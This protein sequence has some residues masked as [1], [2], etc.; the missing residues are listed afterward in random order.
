MA[1]NLDLS[2]CLSLSVR[3]SR[4]GFISGEI[5]TTEDIPVGSTICSPVPCYVSGRSF[6]EATKTYSLSVSDPASAILESVQM[7]TPEWHYSPATRPLA[8]MLIPVLE[9]TGH[10]VAI[11]GRFYCRGYPPES[12]VRWQDWLRMTLVSDSGILHFE[13]SEPSQCGWLLATLDAYSETTVY[14]ENDKVLSATVVDDP[15]GYANLV[16]VSVHDEWV[17][18]KGIEPT[19]VVEKI[20]GLTIT[21][22]SIGDQILSRKEVDSVSDIEQTETWE[23]DDEGY[24]TK[25]KKVTFSPDQVRPDQQEKEESIL[26][27][28]ISSDNVYSYQKRTVLSRWDWWVNDPTDDKLQW[29]LCEKRIEET[30]GS[31]DLAGYSEVVT[32]LQEEEKSKSPLPK[33]MVNVSKTR[34]RIYRSSGEGKPSQERVLTDRWKWDWYIV[35]VAQDLEWCWVPD[36]GSVV[37]GGENVESLI[38]SP[39]QKV[40]SIHLE[41]TARDSESIAAL[42]EIKKE[43]SVVGIPDMESLERYARGE[44]KECSRIRKA[45]L[46]IPL[47]G[48]GD[49]HE[50]MPIPGCLVFWKGRPWLVHAVETNLPEHVLTVEMELEPPLEEIKQA[51]LGVPKAAEAIIDLIKKHGKTTTNVERGT[52]AGRISQGRYLVDVGGQQKVRAERGLVSGKDDIPIGSTVLLA[53]PSGREPHWTILERPREATVI[54][55]TVE[56]LPRD[57]SWEVELGP[58][59]VVPQGNPE[60]YPM[61]VDIDWEVKKGVDKIIGY[62][63]RVENLVP[64]GRDYPGEV[65]VG[66]EVPEYHSRTVQV[67]LD[68]IS[69]LNHP[70]LRGI[71]LTDPTRT[72]YVSPLV[73]GWALPSRMDGTG[74][75]PVDPGGAS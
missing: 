2:R 54:C 51:M 19:S 50:D 52:V 3:T 5:V 65:F 72:V 16:V 60:C 62:A 8:D 15:G 44:L 45:R 66:G 61:L 48:L 22:D 69:N 33:R 35:N 71:V 46:E 55:S 7:E 32:E 17:Q 58:L 36:G 11:G 14:L 38:K 13:R 26:T 70:V 12:P 30:S 29:G 47:L 28:S 6:D 4:M 18:E 9:K 56:R 75:V 10:H 43:I 39:P 59:N 63:L 23:Y 49:Y 64:D 67:S 21:T 24:C 41:A 27:F 37:G 73:E 34:T 57:E 20:G 1:V 74:D 40:N 53:R 25:Y 42:G 68:R 31:V